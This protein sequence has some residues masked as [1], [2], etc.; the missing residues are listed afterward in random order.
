MSTPSLDLFSIRS[1]TNQDAD[2][3]QTLVF[4]VLAEYGFTPDPSGT[5]SDLTDIETAYFNLGGMFEI[6]EAEDGALAGTIGLFP[7]DHSTCELRKMYLLPQVRGLGLGKLL[8]T[9]AI[10]RAR[11]A[12]FKRIVLETA[13]VLTTAAKLYTSFGFVP[14][15]PDHLSARC[16]QAYALDLTK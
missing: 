15:T 13:S 14:I 10:E 11:A 5:D 7:L 8:L 4:S 16:D 2:R 3:I 12:G 1:A 6:A 9:R